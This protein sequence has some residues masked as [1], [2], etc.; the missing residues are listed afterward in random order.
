MPFKSEQQRK[1]CFYE[2]NKA[3]KENK[4]PLWD[5]KKFASHTGG[6]RF[7]KTMTYSTVCKLL[8][9][10]DLDNLFKTDRLV[11][12]GSTGRLRS[13]PEDIDILVV[14][15]DLDMI[16]DQFKKKF[17]FINFIEHGKLQSYFLIYFEGEIREI[18]LWHT[19]KKSF[20]Y[21]YFQYAFPKQT[22][23]IFRKKAKSL[24][25]LLNQYG[26]YDGDNLIKIKNYKDIFK[27]LQ[28]NF[29][30]PI[31]QTIRDTKYKKMS[32]EQALALIRKNNEEEKRIKKYSCKK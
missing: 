21:A 29:R 25:L 13:Y 26:L 4:K 15:L 3:I 32:T 9:E 16:I 17:D 12:V 7:G 5:C 28:I 19:T 14:G 30:T 20:P 22:T 24:G 2:Y 27:H 6:S 31:E 1:K 10:L 8:K 18:N 23:I 11:L